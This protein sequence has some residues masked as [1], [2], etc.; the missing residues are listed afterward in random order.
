M[1]ARHISDD[2]RDNIKKNSIID[3]ELQVKMMYEFFG[4]VQI[5]VS[6]LCQLETLIPRINP[7]DKIFKYA[8][9]FNTCLLY[10]SPSPRDGLL[11]R[12]PSS[13]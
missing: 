7:G 1:F 10:T 2:K 9:A 5:P 12:M 13:A 8:T 6:E 3:S 4:K 11:S